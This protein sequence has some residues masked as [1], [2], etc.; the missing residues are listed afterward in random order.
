MLLVFGLHTT[1]RVLATPARA[2]HRCG[3]HA[4]HQVVEYA[5]KFS[6]FFIPVFRVGAARYFDTCTV[7][8]FETE[9]SKAQA[10]LAKTYTEPVTLS[11]T[12][13][14]AATWTPQDR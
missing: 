2:C 8:G 12:P 5:R 1:A 9:Q 4:P 7:C 6:L 13:Q 3:H 14:D 11:A 10:Q